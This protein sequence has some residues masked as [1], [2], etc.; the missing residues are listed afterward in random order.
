MSKINGKQDFRL[1]NNDL[2]VEIRRGI[3]QS[4]RQIFVFFCSELDTA[5]FDNDDDSSF[6]A[7]SSANLNNKSINR[8]SSNPDLSP[9]GVSNKS[10]TSSSS[11]PGNEEDHSTFVVKVYRSDQSFKY[12][13]VHKVN[14]HHHY[15]STFTENVRSSLGHNSKATCY[16]GNY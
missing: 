7:P 12:F 14:H 6:L 3:N 11:V 9:A 8:S 13:P 10:I 5:G 2:F 15:F 16:V 1:I 4:I